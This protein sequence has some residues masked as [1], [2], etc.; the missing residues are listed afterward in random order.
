MRVE[1]YELKVYT[2]F[3]EPYVSGFGKIYASDGS[4]AGDF[5]FAVDGATGEIDASYCDISPEYQNNGFGGKFIVRQE[6]AAKLAG[7][8]KFSLDANI[9]VGGY[10]WARAGYDFESNE[11]RIRIIETKLTPLVQKW[12]M[13]NPGQKTF[14]YAKQNIS[15]L[16]SRT[17]KHSWQIAAFNAPDGTRLGKNALLGSHWTGFKNLNDKDRGFQVGMKYYTE[18]IQR[19]P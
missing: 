1:I 12:V 14:P 16:L 4:Q 9:D 2:L 11:R 10:A 19:N 8:K 15:D 13:A 7:F 17:L 5:S 3:K 18:M 6:M